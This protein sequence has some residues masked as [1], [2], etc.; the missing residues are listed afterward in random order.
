MSIFKE[1]FGGG[2]SHEK[3]K[4]SEIIEDS[5]VMLK[6][7]RH[8]QKEKDPNKTNEELLLSPAGRVNAFETGKELNAQ[9]EVSVAAGS[10]LIRSQEAALLLMLANNENISPTDSLDTIKDKIKENLKV[11]TK[12]YEDE[13]LGFLV[14]GDVRTEAYKADADGRYMEWLVDES[15]KQ[16]IETNDQESTTFSRQA[17]NIAE[18]FDKYSQVGNNFNRLVNEKD[19]YKE[20]GN[21]L[22][23]YLGTHASVPESFIYKALLIQEGKMAAQKFL[24]NNK[25]CWKE[26]TGLDVSIKNHGSEQNIHIIYADG[27]GQSELILK[28]ETV[29]EIINERND[30]ENNISKSKTESGNDKKRESLDYIS[31]R[32]NEIKP[33]IINNYQDMHEN[34]EL[35]GQEFETAKKIEEYLKSLG[36]EIIADKIGVPVNKEK[37]GTGIIAR[38]NGKKD[39]AT[40]AM[41]ADM[42]AL[43]IQESKEHEIQSKNKGVMHACGH[44]AHSASLMGA[45]KILKELADQD[46]LDGNVVL[47]FQPSEERASQ[48]ES[49][50]V[51]MVRTLE[52]KGLREE[53]KGFF[54]LHVFAE[55]PR[56]TIQL[57]EGVETASTSNMEIK[58]ES[59]GGHI[60]NAY[61]NPNLKDII[62]RLTLSL[63]G[64]FRKYYED[65]TA[66]VASSETKYKGASQNI[67][68]SEAKDNWVIRVL[69]DD[70]KKLSQEIRGKIKQEAQEAIDKHLEEINKVRALKGK[71]N[72]DADRIKMEI[73]IQSGYR[74]TIHRSP[75]LVKMAGESAKE[76]IGDKLKIVDEVMMGAEDFSFYLEKFNGKQIPGVFVMVGSAN[77][78]KG[79]PI[80]SHHS[81]EFKIDPEV[82]RDLSAM[83]STY[84]VNFFDKLKK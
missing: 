18:I 43:P 81:P 13:R 51:Q 66:L 39:G 71:E 23:R 2:S 72:F 47:L 70:Y 15:D 40:L 58:L 75:E 59:P 37:G 77:P 20:F 45:A 34:P 73:T 33:E 35:G 22:E 60:I 26:L 67:L 21:H 4:P 79:Y 56:G 10:Q 84:A 14:K 61:D 3:E 83:Y 19:N 24:E 49:G 7:R 27:N 31:N 42:D 16:A 1:I 57:R 46:K 12:I 9:L 41:R 80:G 44:D 25:N 6:F 38:I 32:A 68:S 48:K 36:I 8:A 5:E 69:S 62:S 82:T 76:V 17:G 78:E 55:L 30:F 63:N 29:K 53:I 28:P 50:A 54:G 74:P 64:I 65:E 11:G 52:A